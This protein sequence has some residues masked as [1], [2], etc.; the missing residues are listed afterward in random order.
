MCNS[1]RPTSARHRT[2]C[3]YG[4][5][6]QH[7]VRNRLHEEVIQRRVT[8]DPRFPRNIRDLR[9]NVGYYSREVDWADRRATFFR[10]M[11]LFVLVSFG[12]LSGAGRHH[13]GRGGN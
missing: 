9:L 7:R 5:D 6:L 13:E 2:L 10:E 3:V 4:I 12:E 1:A 11:F 8:P